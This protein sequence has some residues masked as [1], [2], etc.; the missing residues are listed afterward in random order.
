VVRTPSTQRGWQQSA[1]APARADLRLLNYLH[2]SDGVCPSAR[3]WPRKTER[4]IKIT[5]QSFSPSNPPGESKMYDAFIARS[6]FAERFCYSLIYFRWKRPSQHIPRI[7]SVIFYFGVCLKH[8]MSSALWKRTIL[9]CKLKLRH[10]TAVLRTCMSAC[11]LLPLGLLKIKAVRSSE[12]SVSFYRT[13]WCHIQG[14]IL[15]SNLGSGQRLTWLRVFVVFLSPRTKNATILPRVG[16]NRVLPN[17]FKFIIVPNILCYI[18]KTLIK[19]KVVP[20][21][22]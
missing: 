22:N 10:C 15:G 20:V 21:L 9:R 5:Q 7:V 12:T 16:Y 1:G 2:T 11:W 8:Q 18:V 14:E 17:P 19:G 3:M 6:V 13:T 4:N